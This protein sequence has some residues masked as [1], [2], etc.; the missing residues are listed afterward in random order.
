VDGA[1]Q[2]VTERDK[3]RKGLSWQVVR[4]EHDVVV[5]QGFLA[6]AREL[7]GWRAKGGR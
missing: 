3:R 5:D 4:V 1:V 2:V 6:V 7:P